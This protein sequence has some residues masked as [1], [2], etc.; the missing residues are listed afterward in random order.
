MKESNPITTNIQIPRNIV[1]G[2]REGD[3]AIAQAS[4]PQITQIGENLILIQNGNC[5]YIISIIDCEWLCSC[6][7]KHFFR[8]KCKRIFAVEFN[9]LKQ[10]T[11]DYPRNL[12]RWQEAEYDS[13]ESRNRSS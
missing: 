8:V 2:R 7:E 12:H 13:A 1:N 3:L 9:Q 4:R 11:P 10:S 5:E 6:T